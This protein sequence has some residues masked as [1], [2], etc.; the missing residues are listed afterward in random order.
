[1]MEGR[2]VYSVDSLQ[3]EMLANHWQIE[4]VYR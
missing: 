2:L 4:L 3:P 1:M